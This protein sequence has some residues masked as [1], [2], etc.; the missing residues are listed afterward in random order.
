MKSNIFEYQF[1]VT[2][3]AI[4]DM[5]H[6]NNVVY[7][8]W[9]QNVAKKHWESKANDVIRN[10]YVWV[11]LNHFIEYHNP[12]FEDDIIT[13][14]TWIDHHKGVKSERHTKIINSKS[15]KTLVSAKTTWCLLHKET[16]RPI[17][18]TEEISALFQAEK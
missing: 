4:D 12:A 10:T 17:R 8:Q 16:L 18:I 2:K 7:L 5:N 11:V 15:N 1:T 14:Q 6:V 9:V 13:L 3:S